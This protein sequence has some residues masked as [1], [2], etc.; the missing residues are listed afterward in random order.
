M[1]NIDIQ[2][3]VKPLVDS[4]MSELLKFF[5][6]NSDLPTLEL[7]S[8]WDEF[9]EFDAK[10]IIT[11][12]TFTC[13]ENEGIDLNNIKKSDSVKVCPILQLYPQNIEE[14]INQ[15]YTKFIH[16]LVNGI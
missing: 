4:L 10:R 5:I 9:K 11:E 1:T 13:I 8:R 12:V 6:D 3:Q 14:A 16:K 7:K 2:K 15:N